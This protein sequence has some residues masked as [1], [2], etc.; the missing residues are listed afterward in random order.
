LKSRKHKR[1][2]SLLLAASAALAL[3]AF[4]S[5]PFVGS[6]AN[7]SASRR[8][9]SH[10]LSP[11]LRALASSNEGHERVRVIVQQD[12]SHALALPL[13]LDSLLGQLD[14]VVTRR[15]AKLGVLSASLPPAALKSL[16][17]RADV[18]YVSVDRSVVAAGHVETTTGT[19]LVRT[20]TTL[21][22]LGIPIG[23]TTL[24]GAGLGI[25]VLDSGIDTRH[26]A[27][28][29]GLGLSRVAVSIDFTGEGR[30]DDP[31]GHGTHVASL[32]AGRG[33]G[34]S[35]AYQ[36]VAPG[37]KLLNLRVLNSTGQGTVSGLLA[38]LDWV[39]QNRALY[40]VRVVNLSLGTLAVDDYHD[41]PLCAAVRRLSDAGVVVVAAAGNSGRDSL[42]NRIYGQV[43]SPGVEPSAITVGASNTFGTDSRAD[44]TV[45]TYSS[46]GPTRGAWA[47]DGGVAHY[48]NL[49][50]PDLVAPGN[51][52][53]GAA[54][55]DNALLASHPELNAEA[56]QSPTRKMM[57]LSGTSMATPVAAGAAALVL[58]SNP[59]LTPNLVKA[60]LSL[61]AQP[62]AGFNHLEQG[63]GEVNVEGA[64]RLAKLVRTDLSNATPLGAPLLTS[65]APATQSQ[66]AGGSF[67]WSQ[68]LVLNHTYATGAELFTLYQRVY[69]TGALLG[70]GVTEAGGQ[71]LNSSLMTSS[72]ALGDHLM[73]SDGSTM[74]GGQ[75]FLD[76]STLLD[77]TL[78]DGI[79][80]GDG[81]MIGDG[82][83][84]GDGIMI[85][86]TTLAAQSAAV[87]G[88]DTACM[89]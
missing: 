17:E 10:K 49:V 82:I 70:D 63:A 80:V 36:G 33:V 64:V 62:L 67:A 72:V 9:A 86:D 23:T 19:S 32:A 29:D 69:G 25:A 81:I 7:A 22:I 56:S 66:I 74:S 4:I 60:V 89:K 85:G 15:F 40:N 24:D 79:M 71:Y 20:Q 2:R 8:G 42:G 26:E 54:A 58:Q 3:C 35:G 31:Y 13:G 87:K 73:T 43:H 38:A 76:A 65:Q 1:L 57:Y 51:K 5:L 50:K 6:R 37:A 34:S 28:R 27:F 44:D 83:M 46:R 41:D 75:F 45:T 53:I 16:A 14:G 61:T 11:E 47:D 39:L 68:G 78:P 21:S 55:D 48:D 77:S 18:R 88:D 30:T 59:A 52:I 84:C 12:A